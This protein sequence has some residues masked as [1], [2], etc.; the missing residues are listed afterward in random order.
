[1]PVLRERFGSNVRSKIWLIVGVIL[2]SQVYAQTTQ[3]NFAKAPEGAVVLFDGA[4]TSKWETKDGNACAWVVVDG[5]LEVTP[6]KGDLYTKDK[7]EDYVLHVEFRTPAPAEGDTGQHR[8][9]SGIF[10]QNMY[11]V[12]VLESYG[13]VATKGDCGS[14]YNIKAPDKNMALKPMEW[15]SYDIT[16]R[17]PRFDDAGKKTENARITLVWNG[18]KVHDNVEI[19]HCTRSAKLPE[20]AGPGPLQLQDHGFAVRYRN[21]WIVPSE[22]K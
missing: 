10:M 12:Q 21:I 7:F 15:Q 9:N 18:E 13:L 4:D 11:E 19:P 2:S 8:G 22:N 14:V 17:A 5:A 16:Y 6:K 3:P 1:M 20:T